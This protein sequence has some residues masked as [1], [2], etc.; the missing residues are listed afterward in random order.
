LYF[1]LEELVYLGAALDAKASVENLSTVGLGKK[2]LE[3][4]RPQFLNGF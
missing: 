4:Y 3:G 2:L 1:G